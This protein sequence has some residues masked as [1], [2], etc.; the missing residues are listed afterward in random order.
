MVFLAL[1]GFQILAYKCIWAWYG[2]ELEKF[3]QE[4]LK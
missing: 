1:Y 3:Q 4:P 2:D